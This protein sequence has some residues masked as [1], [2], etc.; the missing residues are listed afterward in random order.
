M[1]SCPAASSVGPRDSTNRRLRSP[2]PS[3]SR[4]LVLLLLLGLAPAS[5]RLQCVVLVLHLSSQLCSWLRLDGCSPAPP[6]QR[7]GPPLGPSCLSP[8]PSP[9]RSRRTP[10][11]QRTRRS[12]PVTGCKSRCSGLRT[13]L[14]LL[15]LT[16]S[17]ACA[18]QSPRRTPPLVSQAT[19][20]TCTR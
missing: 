16:F 5:L 13:S 2:P 18:P 3:P 7:L 17:S 14:L 15:S 19:S 12:S 10:T 11:P 4:S 8:S 1:R 9:S 6:L 20:G